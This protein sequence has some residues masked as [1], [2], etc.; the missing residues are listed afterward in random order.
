[1]TAES[2]YYCITADE[3]IDASNIEQLV[4]CIH[5]VD[6]EMTVHDNYICLMPVAQTNA[7]T[8]VSCNKDALLHMNIRIQDARGQYYDKYSTMTGTKNGIAAQIKELNGQCLLTHC[9]CHSLDLAV[10]DTIKSI[11]LLM[12]EAYEITKLKEESQKRGRIPQKTSRNSGPN[13]I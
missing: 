3:S 12:P 1:M 13:G 5:W 11:P 10:R 2:G 9:Y 7:A 4:I 8:T 6:K